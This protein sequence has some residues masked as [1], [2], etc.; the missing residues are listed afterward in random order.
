MNSTSR[1]KR[2]TSLRVFSIVMTVVLGVSLFALLFSILALVILPTPEEYEGSFPSD[3]PLFSERFWSNVTSGILRHLLLLSE[4]VTA[5]AIVRIVGLAFAT[6]LVYTIREKILEMREAEKEAEMEKKKGKK[7]KKMRIE[8]SE[9]I[10]WGFGSI[11]TAIISSASSVEFRIEAAT[12]ILILSISAFVITL[13][14]PKFG[15]LDAIRD[16]ISRKIPSNRTRR[17][18][19]K[20]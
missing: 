12:I 13:S 16:W 8:I 6:N 17:R 3:P 14:Y 19:E 7:V 15:I 9:Y 2:V 1:S 10:K 4:H 11:I 5:R 18:G 20:E